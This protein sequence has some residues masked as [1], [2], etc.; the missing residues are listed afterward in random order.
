MIINL[1]TYSQTIKIFLYKKKT[2]KKIMENKAKL[3]LEFGYGGTI[4]TI[5]NIDGGHS[6]TYYNIIVT[7]QKSGRRTVWSQEGLEVYLKTYPKAIID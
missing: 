7:E 2:E 5:I 6:D 1:L 3:G 4:H